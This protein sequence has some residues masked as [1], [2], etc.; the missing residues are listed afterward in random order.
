ME[1]NFERNETEIVA[2]AEEL[3]FPI[4]ARI[5]EILEGEDKGKYLWTISHY[6]SNT[7]KGHTYFPS[8]GIASTKVEIEESIK[9]YVDH[10]FLRDT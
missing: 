1:V 2:T 4:K 9:R 10:M 5:S 8:S 7:A 6:C 3:D